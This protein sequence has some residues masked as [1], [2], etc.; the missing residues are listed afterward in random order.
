MSKEMPDC[1]NCIPDGYLSLSIILNRALERAAVGKGAKRHADYH[2]QPFEQQDICQIT[3]EEGHGGVRFQ[4]RKKVKEISRLPRKQDQINELL[5]VIVYA[6]ADILVLQ[7]ELERE[8][9]RREAGRSRDQD[10]KMVRLSSP[11]K[12]E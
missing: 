6:A 12:T 4:L 7:E 3:R 1:A 11:T 9:K 8:F 10:T 2:N 5:D